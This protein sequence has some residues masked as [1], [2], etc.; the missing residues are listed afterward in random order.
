MASSYTLLLNL[1]D[2]AKHRAKTNMSESENKARRFFQE[3]GISPTMA[4][5]S[6]V[7]S[8]F[9]RNLNPLGIN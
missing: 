3:R 8:A 1:I 2:M 6:R 5:F 7:E 4:E 9:R